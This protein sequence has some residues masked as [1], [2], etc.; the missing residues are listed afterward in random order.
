MVFLFR[1]CQ[2]NTYDV[3]ITSLGAYTLFI[4]QSQRQEKGK[5]NIRV[6]NLVEITSKVKLAI[7]IVFISCTCKK[8][9]YRKY[10]SYYLREPSK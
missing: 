2:Y 10:R 3:L 9:R 4:N 5:A 1:E 8:H 7:H 6:E